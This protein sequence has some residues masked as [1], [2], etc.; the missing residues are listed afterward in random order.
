[1]IFPHLETPPG[2]PEFE[3]HLI[4]AAGEDDL[5]TYYVYG[6]LAAKKV[7]YAFAE[8]RISRRDKEAHHIVF[9][10]SRNGGKDWSENQVIVESRNGEC[11]CNPTPIY[12]RKRNSIWLFYAQNYDNNR[13]EIYLISSSDEGENWT[14]PIN[15]T[16]LF[17][18]NSYDWTF[19]LPGPGHGIQM[20][21]GRLLLQIWHR[22]EIYY[23]AKER[24]Y[25]VSVIFSDD[26]GENWLTGGT[27]PLAAAQLNESR[28]V[29]LT[30]GGLLLNARSGAFVTSPRYFSRSS[31][32]GLHWSVPQ[33]ISSLSPAYAT[34]SGLVRITINNTDWLILT[35]PDE[36]DE[37]RRLTVFVSD[38][39]GISWE[40]VGV[41]YNG[42]AGYS[43]A[44]VLADNSIGVIYGR[45]LLNENFDV[46]GNIRRTM[47]VRFNLNGLLKQTERFSD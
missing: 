43:D 17:T 36:I 42:F 40:K 37:R 10:K 14:T 3:E 30:N 25:G 16:T 39:R 4:W 6:L 21:S 27:V 2:L 31:D 11:F 33:T 32:G 22:R 1:M 23:P 35:R 12:N 13:S 19:H 29:E 7:I 44:V 26:G 9:K 18:D 20:Q 47:F 28:I 34:D 24:N 8:G 15:L 45:D 46:E 41:I 38:D 5:E